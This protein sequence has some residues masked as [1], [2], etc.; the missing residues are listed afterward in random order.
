MQ[1]VVLVTIGTLDDSLV[2]PREVFKPAIVEGASAIVLSHN[3]PS[4]DPTPGREDIQVTNRLTEAG[5]LLGIRV[6]DHI[7][8]GDGTKQLHS[9]RE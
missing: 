7:I 6:L 4:S 1:S 3:H 2:H 8:H 5:E 9:I